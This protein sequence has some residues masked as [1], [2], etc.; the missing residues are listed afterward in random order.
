MSNVNT[1]GQQSSLG[2]I[3]QLPIQM[4]VTNQL[5]VNQNQII[6]NPSSIG[7]VAANPL[8]LHIGQINQLNGVPNAAMT[9]PPQMVNIVFRMFIQGAGKY[10]NSR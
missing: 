10:G 5:L 7:A 2:Q 4:P 9:M 8:G 3:G 1:F 6:T